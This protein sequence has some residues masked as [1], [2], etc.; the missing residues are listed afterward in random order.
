[1]KKVFVSVINDLS[2][3]Q[4]VD[5]VCKTLLSLGFDVTL[6]GRKKSDSRRLAKRK[7]KTHR[8]KLIFEKGPLFYA[9]YNFRL[10]IFLLFRKTELLVSNDL[11]TLLSNYLIHKIKRV[12]VVYDS[13]ELFTETPEVINRKFVKSVWEKIEKWIFPKL[14]HVFTVSGSIAEIFNEKYGVNVKVVRNVPP[15]RKFDPEGSGSRK[16]LDLPEEKKIVVLHTSKLI[17]IPNSPRPL[18]ARH[19]QKKKHQR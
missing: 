14:K 8:M 15:K 9:E 2:T 17:K 16:E 12:P 13:H 18:P 7:Y 10:F 6:M 11:D 4:R 1:L 3:D 19:H 5:K